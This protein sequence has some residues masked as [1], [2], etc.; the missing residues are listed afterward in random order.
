MSPVAKHRSCNFLKK[1]KPKKTKQKPNKQ[2]FCHSF[3]YMGCKILK[4]NVY[5]ILSN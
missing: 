3:V 2:S 4:S 1:K 5:Q